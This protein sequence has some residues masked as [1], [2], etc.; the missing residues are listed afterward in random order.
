MYDAIRLPWKI[1]EA[2]PG[3]GVYKTTDGGTKWEKVAAGLPQGNTGRIGLD[4]CRTRPDSVYAVIDNF[5][6]RSGSTQQ[7]DT[8]FAAPASFIGGEVYRTDDA[9]R[10]WRRVSAEGE[11]VSRKAG[12]SFNQLRVDPNNP[13]RV[14]ITG[15]NMIQSNDG[16]KTWAGLGGGGG[17]GRGGYPFASTFGDFRSLWIDSEDSEHM[18]ATS[19]GGVSV[20]YDGGRTSDHFANLKL[21]EFYAIGVD[22]EQ[23]Y[24]IFGGLQDH[25]SWMGPSNGWSGRINIDDWV[26]VG[27]GDGMYNEP[28]PTGRWLYNT[29]EFGTLGRVDLQTRTRTIIDP[30]KPNS[31]HPFTNIR[32]LG[33]RGAAAAPDSVLYRFNWIAPIRISPQDSN[34]IY[35]GAQ[36][37][38]RS[39]DR[40]DHWEVISPDLTTNNPEKINT[41]NTSI[42]HCTIVTIAEAAAQAGVIW[43]GTDDG[44]VQVTR[45]AGAHWT[46]TTAKVAAAGGP[47]DAWVPRVYA[48]RFAAGTAYVTKSRRRQDDYKPW[49][50]RTT[51]FGA[52]WTRI[53]SGLPD[54][55]EATSIV[56]DTVNPNLLFLGTS[57]GVFVSFDRGADWAPF[58]STMGPAPVTDLLV[59]PREG[60]LV[61]GTYGRGVWVANIVP[62]RGINRELLSSEAALL[63]IRSFAER[64]EGSFGNYR[65]LGDRYPVTPNEPNA[66]TVAFYLKEAPPG[67]AAAAPQGGRGGR[68]GFGGPPCVA[69]GG[70]GR[71]PYLTIADA[72]GKTVCTLIPTSR[73]GVNQVLWSLNTYAPQSASVRMPD[74]VAAAEL[75]ASPPL[76]PATIRLHSMSPARPTCR[77]PA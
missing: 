9:G 1:M 52:T 37:L 27:I 18:I 47:E 40:G 60:D 23:P 22:M 38:L 28:D 66:M 31:P 11:D 63:P 65:L 13:D 3:G 72:S 76:R 69:D 5:T 42:Q 51:D 14:F 75:Q 33:G 41:Q 59:H 17:G 10:V 25:E 53:T 68:G 77:K 4:I 61:V 12:Y 26:S 57:A 24:R 2:R 55:A 45:D 44:K 36:F 32:P 30:T 62:L 56:E 67:P 21:G 48:S 58:K 46:D 6:L 64:N 71:R 35:Y 8:A 54:V 15:S 70:D 29:Q 34:T 16:G 73:A 20:S 43:V 39:E 7:V 49:V 50:F 19:D 74:A